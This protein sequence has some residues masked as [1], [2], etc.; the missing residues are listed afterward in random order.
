MNLTTGMAAIAIGLG[1]AVAGPAGAQEAD[2]GREGGNNAVNL[3]SPRAR[4]TVT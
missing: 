4:T 2:E 1:L 3:A